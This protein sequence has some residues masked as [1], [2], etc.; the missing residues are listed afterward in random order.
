MNANADPSELDKFD[1]LA[2]EWWNPQ[3]PLSTLHAIN[4]LRIAYIEARAPLG[5]AR[6]L[7]VGCG[8]GI[9]SE[10]MAARG[11]DVVAID[12]AET[13]IQVAR[14]HAAAAGLTVDYRLASVDDIASAEHAPSP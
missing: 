14:S 7:D 10:A 2:T 13:S 11:A 4:P 9:L 6:V 12:L 3:G 5:A 8:A 1:R